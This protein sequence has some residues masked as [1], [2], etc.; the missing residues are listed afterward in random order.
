LLYM[1]CTRIK[2]IASVKHPPYY[3]PYV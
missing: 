3:Y 1:H 2:L